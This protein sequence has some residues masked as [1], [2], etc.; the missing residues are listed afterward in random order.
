MGVETSSDGATLAQ[1]AVNRIVLARKGRGFATVRF[2]GATDLNGGAVVYK[3]RESN[4]AYIQS[5]GTSRINTGFKMKPGVR[6]DVDYEYTGFLKNSDR[7]FGGSGALLYLSGSGSVPTLMYGDGL[8]GTFGSAFS[9]LQTGVRYHTTVT[10]EGRWIDTQYETGVTNYDRQA[11]TSITTEGAN[12][13]YLFGW[14]NS[15]NYSKAK[16][17]RFTLTV[18]GTVAYD[19]VPDE[20]NGVAGF[21]DAVGGGFIS[22]ASASAFSFG[23][24]WREGSGL[25]SDMFTTV[26]ANTTVSKDR[27][28]TLTATMPGADS[29]EW[30]KNGEVI[31][32][33]TGD[34]LTVG[35]RKGQGYDVYSVRAVKTVAGA[36]IRSDAVS[37]TVE[38]RPSA[39]VMVVR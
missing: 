23:C 31:A 36:T 39:F 17:Y 1:H 27:T 37:A 9:G 3:V 32:G 26:P 14:H 19:F 13:L 6:I 24:S 15:G 5:D 38:F 29:Y 4:G 8:S 7:L 20:V 33:A 35:W 28:T 25:R 16:I 11:S 18:D 22:G 21:T 10:P 12:P 34:S 2:H 30:L